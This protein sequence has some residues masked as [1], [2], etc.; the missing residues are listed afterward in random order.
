MRRG[1]TRPSLLA[2]GLEERDGTLTAPAF[3]VQIVRDRWRKGSV[4]IPYRFDEKRRMV[5]VDLPG[6]RRLKLVE[7]LE[8]AERLVRFEPLVFEDAYL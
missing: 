3:A 5:K 4:F 1:E 7:G 8:A 2:F 6:V